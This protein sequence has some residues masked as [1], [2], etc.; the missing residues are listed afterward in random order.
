MNM[1][2]ILI[3]NVKNSLGIRIAKKEK[4]HK[5]YEKGHRNKFRY[6]SILLNYKHI[7]MISCSFQSAKNEYPHGTGRF[8]A[9]QK[10]KKKK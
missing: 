8:A 5:K 7:N 4:C 3:G 1:R 9:I 10:I 2:K 6:L